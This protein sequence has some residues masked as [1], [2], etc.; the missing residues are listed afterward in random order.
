MTIN[1]IT[2]GKRVKQT[3]LA[4]AICVASST[5]F[6]A[7]L[8]VVSSGG[9]AAAYKQLAPG[10]EQKTGHKLISGWGPSM[11]DTKEAIPN[12]L[13]RGETIDVVI[14]VGDSLQ[15]LIDQ[16]KVSKTDHEVLALSRIGMAVK[17]GAPQPDISSVD[18]LKT[19]LLNA[20]SIAYSDSASGVYLS[21]VLFKR[22]G[23]EE[24]LKGKARMIPGDPV[25]HIVAR[26]DAEIGFQQMSEL[27]PVTG[28]DIVGPLPDAAQQITAFSAGVVSNTA[29]PAAAKALV[30]YLSSP[31]VVDQ[32]KRTG[33][34]PAPHKAK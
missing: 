32:I 13:N 12:R 5:S 30:D 18:A 21:T 8:Y 7:D 4:V 3:V 10:F 20:K 33:L 15:R 6:A 14:M 9:F 29:Q 22:L 1:A 2:L 24:Q 23:I 31:D 17:A 16:G 19:T 34:D 28:I 26:G 11:G 27:K 25:G